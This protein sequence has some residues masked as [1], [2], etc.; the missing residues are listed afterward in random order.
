MGDILVSGVMEDILVT[1][2]NASREKFGEGVVFEVELIVST[3]SGKVYR[4]TCR[5]ANTNWMGSL[6]VSDRGQKESPKD[7]PEK[8]LEV[9]ELVVLKGDPTNKAMVVCEIGGGDTAY[10]I[11]R[12]ADGTVA[13]A[14]VPVKCLVRL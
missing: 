13:V 9:G 14:R 6:S 11:Y 2:A 10:V 12:K 1:A 7:P 4:Q 8:P 3:F 5:I